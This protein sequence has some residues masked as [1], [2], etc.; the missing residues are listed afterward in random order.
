MRLD[1]RGGGQDVQVEGERG[2]RQAQA[3]GDFSSWEAERGV[4]DEE[5][6]D[7]EARLLGERGKGIDRLE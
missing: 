6:E 2:P 4:A 1:E 7:V 5:A 3:A